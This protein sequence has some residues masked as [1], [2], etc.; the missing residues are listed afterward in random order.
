M[1]KGLV[2]RL[3]GTAVVVAALGLAA[4]PALAAAN[5]IKGEHKPPFKIGW[6]NIYSVPTWMKQTQGTI[7]DMANQLKKQGL[8][9]SSSSPTPGQRQYPDPA[10][11][12]DDRRQG[13]RDHRR[14]P[15]R[16]PRSTA[17]IAD[18]CAKGIAV[19][20]F[21]SLV[22]TEELTTKIDTDQHEWG[23]LAAEWL[24]K[25]LGGKGKI[26]VLNGPAGVS[27][28]DDRRKGRSRCSRPIRASRSSAETNTPYNAAP[29][30]EAVTN[31]LFSNP[32]IDGVL[33]PG[34]RALGGCGDSRSTSRAAS[35]CR[36]PARTTGRSSRCGRRRSSPPGRRSSRTGSAAFAVYAA[37]EALQGKDIPAYIEV[38]LPIIDESNLDSTSRAAKDFA[39]DGY[40][41]SPYDHE[42]FDEL[43]AKS[44]KK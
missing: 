37:V 20:N 9:E 5:C 38:P 1:V 17:S 23:K 34:R 3:L 18:A 43:I 2:G 25:Q 10:D 11:P 14:S 22:D 41:Y 19:T 40:I 12:V 28:S 16:R 15:A 35:S 42:L 8:V 7:E 26:L 27:V 36:S 13:R 4:A 30:Q 32:Q 44:P 39:A 29:A 33:S 31:L 6:A 21:D 24:V